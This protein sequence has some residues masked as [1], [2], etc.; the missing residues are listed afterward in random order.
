[1][2]KKQ[3]YTYSLS[4]LEVSDCMLVL[5]GYESSR[6]TLKEIEFAKELGIPVYYD[7]NE[8]LRRV[9]P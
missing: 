7:I 3:F 8:F 4:W 9:S 1:M 6:G 2:F 5:N